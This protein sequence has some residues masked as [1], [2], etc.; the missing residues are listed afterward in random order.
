MKPGD[1][2]QA[3]REGTKKVKD[4]TFDEVLDGAET[5]EGRAERGPLAAA[6]DDVRTL[7]SLVRAYKNREYREI[8]YYS[9]AAAVA[10]LAYVL[11]PVDLIPDFLP[12]V[13]LVD[14]AAVVAAC[15]ASLREDLSRFRAWKKRASRAP[16]ANR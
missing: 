3:L 11:S 16:T 7:L 4:S 12:G 1:A 13:G 10:A 15:V 14:D 2:E 8:P 6:V 9:I 5:I